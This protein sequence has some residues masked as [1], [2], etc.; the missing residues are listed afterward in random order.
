VK[1]AG[2]LSICAVLAVV[3]QATSPAPASGAG[4]IR[5]ADF[6]THAVQVTNLRSNFGCGQARTVLRQLL[7]RGVS[8]LPV[9]TRRAGK[10]GCRRSGNQRVC[11]R[12]RSRRAARQVKFRAAAAR[13]GTPQPQPDP[14][15][16][17]VDP[18]QHCIGAWNG[19]GLNLVLYA[20]HFYNDHHIRDGWVFTIPNPAFPS[21]LRCQVVFVVP[22]DD[23]YFTTEFGQDGEILNPDG[24][25][26]QIMP[27]DT[28]IQN[29]AAQHANVT[30]AADGT[31]QKKS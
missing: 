6:T 21:V 28:T 9:K 26:W 1:Q 17:P 30:L 29:A 8:A 2:A 20:K 22:T 31:L 24:N 11:T 27:K 3:C 16:V 19:D 12:Y 7:R 18:V 13:N 15:P 23:P 14:S 4:F 5:C 25:G 10:W